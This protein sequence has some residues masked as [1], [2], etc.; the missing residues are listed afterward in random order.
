MLELVMV[1]DN[2]S[3]I[4]ARDY[5]LIRRVLEENPRVTR[6]QNRFDD[7]EEEVPPDD[8]PIEDA[9]DDLVVDENDEGMDDKEEDGSL[10][11]VDA[12]EKHGKGEGE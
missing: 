9:D 12:D 1:G 11:N 7:P 5:R 6:F 2:D 10:G 4:D 3:L 8:G